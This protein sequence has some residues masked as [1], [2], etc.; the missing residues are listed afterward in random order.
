MFELETRACSE[1]DAA[2]LF[3]LILFGLSR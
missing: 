1:P 2:D 3:L